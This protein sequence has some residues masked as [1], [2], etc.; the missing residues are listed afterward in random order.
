MGSSRR[1][2]VFDCLSLVQ[3][4]RRRCLDCVR[5][6]RFQA[7]STASELADRVLLQS[8]FLRLRSDRF[9]RSMGAVIVADQC[10]GRNSDDFVAF[11]IHCDEEVVPVRYPLLTVCT[12]GSSPAKQKSSFNDRRKW[13]AIQHCE[14]QNA[15]HRRSTCFILPSVPWHSANRSFE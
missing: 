2:S 15:G 7:I 6:T 4:F 10:K 8:G 1:R 5:C 14:S 3:S 13:L 9:S 12:G 11:E